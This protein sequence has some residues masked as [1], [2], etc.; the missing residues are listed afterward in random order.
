MQAVWFTYCSVSRFWVKLLLRP[1]I[2]ACDNFSAFPYPKDSCSSIGLNPVTQT[3]IVV[4]CVSADGG[5]RP[6]V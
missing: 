5:R 3:S 2:A 6:E 1:K 4:V